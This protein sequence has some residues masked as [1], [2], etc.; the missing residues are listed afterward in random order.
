ML[1]HDAR[2]GF[3]LGAILGGGAGPL[4]K[5]GFLLGLHARHHFGLHPGY[6]LLVRET[7]G[8]EH[9]LRLGARLFCFAGL[10][11]G[12]FLD[13]FFGGCARTQCGLRHALG[14]FA[15]LAFRF[16]LAFDFDLR[17]AFG[18]LACAAFDL[19]F[20]FGLFARL[21]FGFDARLDF[22]ACGGFGIGAC[23][24]VFTRFAFGFGQRLGFFV[25]AAHL[26]LGLL[27]GSGLD[28]GARLGFFARAAFGFAALLRFF[29]RCFGFGFVGGFFNCG[30]GLG[31]GLR[32]AQLLFVGFQFGGG[33]TAT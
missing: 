25:H 20:G 16:E 18:L 11:V 12:R 14:F 27:A 28:T 1:L 5:N 24:G 13:Q 30:L 10:L 22:G 9:A 17:V 3:L 26:G 29:T 21:A 23:F 7:G 4:F 6:C 2:D 31:G 33:A 8:V 15:R 19:D 32:G